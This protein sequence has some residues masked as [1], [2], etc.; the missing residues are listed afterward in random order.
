LALAPG[1]LSELVLNNDSVIWSPQETKDQ[2]LKVRKSWQILRYPLFAVFEQIANT[3]DRPQANQPIPGNFKSDEVE[4]K[5]DE[6]N[7]QLQLI[8]PSRSTASLSGAQRHA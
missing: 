8:L 4:M 5:I 6:M 3:A 1:I 7:L 2:F